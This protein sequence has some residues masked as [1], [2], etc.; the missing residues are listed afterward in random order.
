MDTKDIHTYPELFE[1]LKA[2]PS[3][4]FYD[5]IQ[6]RWRGKDKQESC[7]RMFSSMNLIHKIEGFQRCNGNFNR[8]TLNFETTLRDAFY[9]SSDNRHAERQGRR[10]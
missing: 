3:N 2:I 4:R 8:R 6:E 5:W 7:L 9:D 1:Q 10:L